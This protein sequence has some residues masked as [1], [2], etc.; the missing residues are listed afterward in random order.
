MTRDRINYFFFNI[1]RK[2]IIANKFDAS[3]IYPQMEIGTFDQLFSLSFSQYS[4]LATISM[5]IQIWRE[6]EPQGVL[7]RPAKNTTWTRTKMACND[8]LIMEITIAKYEPKLSFL[9]N[10]CRIYLRITSPTL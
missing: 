5:C 7:L 1:R 2:S 4:H 10:Q 9:I 6:T 8:K 3:I